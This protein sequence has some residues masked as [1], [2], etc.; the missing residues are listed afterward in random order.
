M[1][2]DTPN[3]V[4]GMVCVRWTYK[5]CCGPQSIE[6]GR[7]A[8]VADLGPGLDSGTDLLL[9]VEPLDCKEI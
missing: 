4:E 8:G 1:A 3:S 5:Y 6:E 7:R 2:C 9:W